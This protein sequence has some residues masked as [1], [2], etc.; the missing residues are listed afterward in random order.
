MKINVAY[1]DPQSYSNLEKYDLGLMSRFPNNNVECDFYCSYKLKSK[2]INVDSL[3]KVFKY[4]D[5]NNPFLKLISYFISLVKIFS[6]IYTKKPDIVHVQW[7]KFPLLD[8]ILYMMVR[9][10]SA[11][12][13][14]VLTVHNIKPHK[15]SCLYWLQYKI[16]YYA[17]DYYIVHDHHSSSKLSKLVSMDKIEVIDHGIIPFENIGSIAESV[18]TLDFSKTTFCFLGAGSSYKGLDILIETWKK[19]FSINSDVQLIIAGVLDN[20]L[21]KYKSIIEAIP[22]IIHFN[23]YMEENELK[24]ISENSTVALLPYKVIS[25][26]GVLLSIMSTNTPFLVTNVGGLSEP[27]NFA[28]VG[29]VIGECSSK[30]IYNSINKVILNPKYYTDMRSDKKSWKQIKFHYSWARISNVTCEFYNK[31]IK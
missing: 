23:R 7:C 25:Q 13:K 22:N 3:H 9:F 15:N 21:S 20:N 18:S 11:K 16:V 30:N 12:S 8:C 6:G 19:R 17:F 4:N 14:L 24:I 29:E 28:N 5:I 2:G 26:S 31:V 10:F 27:L 1:I